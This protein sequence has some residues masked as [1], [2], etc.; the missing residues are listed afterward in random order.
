MKNY[1]V[2]TVLLLLC[3]F[4]SMSQKLTVAGQFGWSSP[5]GSAFEVNGEEMAKAGLNID[6]DVLYHLDQLNGKLGLGITLNSSLLF[7]ASTADGLDIGL[8]GLSL[9]GVKAHYKFLDSKVTPYA[10]LSTGLSQF[11]TP[12]ISDSNGQVLTKGVKNNSFGLR[13]E[14]GLH[15]GNFFLSVAYFTPMK[16]DVIDEKAGALQFSLGVRIKVM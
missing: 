15:L 12:E 11:E 5:Q 16:Y 4:S 8:Y 1:N 10:S 6:A 13:P 14:V 3:S 2:L 9:Y 7:G